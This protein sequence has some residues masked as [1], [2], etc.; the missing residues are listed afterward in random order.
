MEAIACVKE[1][2][3]NMDVMGT[4]FLGVEIFLEVYEFKMTVFE[5]LYKRGL[6][7]EVGWDFLERV[8]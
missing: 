4:Y 8:N 7:V 5:E 6:A 1:E 2:G 3:V